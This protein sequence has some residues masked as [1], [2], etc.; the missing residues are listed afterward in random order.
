MQRGAVWRQVIAVRQNEHVVENE[1][2]LLAQLRELDDPEWLEWPR[3]YDRR[4][5]ADQ[6]TR[7]AARLETE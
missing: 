1:A 7:V 4:A 2:D 3:S 6:L 5:A